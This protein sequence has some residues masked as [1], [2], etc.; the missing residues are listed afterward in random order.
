MSGVLALIDRIAPLSCNV[1]LAGETGSGKELLARLLHA[2]S[3][4]AGTGRFVAVNAAAVE[5]GL[6]LSELLGHERGA[7]TDAVSRRVGRIESAHRGTLFLDEAADLTLHGQAA[8]LRVIQEREFERVGGSDVIRSEFRLITATNRDLAELVRLKR[9]REDL[10]YRIN[11]VKVD[12]PPLRE[13]RED[14]P[15]LVRFFVSKQSHLVEDRQPEISKDAYRPLIAHS[16]PGNV[17]ELENVVVQTFAA[18]KGKTIQAEDWRGLTQEPK[19]RGQRLPLREDVAR[20]ERS[21]IIAALGAAGGSRT[22]AARLLGIPLQTLQ[23]K[24]RKY[25]LGTKIPNA[26]SGSQENGIF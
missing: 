12:V 8:L 18:W 21:R 16:W 20:F 23:N 10:F 11:V 3:G 17:R 22:Q 7:F 15:E 9:F 14:I 25:G 26:V 4:R 24:C 2:R 6:L 19:E 5:P 13:R 1:L